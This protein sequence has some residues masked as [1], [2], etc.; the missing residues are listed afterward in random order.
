MQ[1]FTL[2]IWHIISFST[3]IKVTHPH[4]NHVHGLMIIIQGM[5]TIIITL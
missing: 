5:D 1:I 4:N 3:I 2:G